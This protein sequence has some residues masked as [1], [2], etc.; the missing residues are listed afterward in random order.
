LKAVQRDAIEAARARAAAKGIT[1]ELT[2]F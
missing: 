1:I 2:E